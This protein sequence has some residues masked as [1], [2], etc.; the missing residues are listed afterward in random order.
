[1]SKLA[2]T[3]VYLKTIVNPLRFQSFVQ[4]TDSYPKIKIP[5]IGQTV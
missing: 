4:V 2:T 5:S 3:A 1:L